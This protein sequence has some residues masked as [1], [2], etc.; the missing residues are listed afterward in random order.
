MTNRFPPPLSA[1][2][3]GLRMYVPGE[4]PS[5]SEP[6]GSAPRGAPVGN[7]GPQYGIQ[8]SATWAA[9]DVKPRQ[10]VDVRKADALWRFSI[11]GAVLVTISYGTSKNRPIVALQAPV[12]ITIPGQFTATVEP[13]DDSG[14]Q[15]VVTLT[16]ATAGDASQARKVV[17]RG[18]ADVALDE[19]A[20]RYFALTASTL[21]ISGVATVVPACSSV[22][23]VAGSVL[24]AGSG[25]QEFEA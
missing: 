17:V 23:L 13:L 24:T 15:A 9:G 6:G 12:V 20:V 7:M 14:A 25:F 1:V 10:L 8:Q 5:V 22:P 19:G 3:Q 4:G 21:T 18:A 11:F 16:E 2:H